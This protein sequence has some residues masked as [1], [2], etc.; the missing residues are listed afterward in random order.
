M[1][2]KETLRHYYKGKRHALTK[3]DITHRSNQ[4][5]KNLNNYFKQHTPKHMCGYQ[6]H[7]NEVDL[8]HFYTDT[9]NKNI[10]LS[11]PIIK[12][13]SCTIKEI[14]NLNDDFERGYNG[15]NEPKKHKKDTK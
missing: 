15:I 6:S 14:Q 8:H 9:L 1:E 10:K 7:Q 11:F 2:S 5:Q 4:I 13:K 12:D 3:E